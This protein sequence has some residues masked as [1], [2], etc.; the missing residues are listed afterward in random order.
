M[1]LRDYGRGLGATLRRS[2]PAV[3][4][5][6]RGSARTT[7]ELAGIPET[8]PVLAVLSLAPIYAR[9]AVATHGMSLNG[10]FC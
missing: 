6:V 9:D 3:V 10:R 1:P 7:R 4:P 5:F 8:E 2:L